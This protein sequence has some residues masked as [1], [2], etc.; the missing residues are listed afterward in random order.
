MP[1]PLQGLD[2]QARA[3]SLA[4]EIESHRTQ[5]PVKISDDTTNEFPAMLVPKDPY[6]SVWQ[7]KQQNIA[8]NPFGAQ[9]KVQFVQEITPE[10]LAY[11]RRKAD[12]LENIQFEKWLHSVIDMSNPA[13]VA[14]ARENG[15]LD[16][17]FEQRKKVIDNA[18]E[19]SRKIAHMRLLGQ[20]SWRYPDYKLAYALKTGVL[21][22]PTGSLMNPASY[23]T[24]GS[25][26]AGY[27]RGYFNPRRF[28]PAITG[29][30]L[31]NREDPFPELDIANGSIIGDISSKQFDGKFNAISSPN[32]PLQ[33]GLAPY[34]P[35]PAQ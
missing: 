26:D 29:G 14:M 12:V 21:K 33:L 11:Q 18:H 27:R 34:K 7:Q 31:K 3:S 8:Q 23:L 4:S 13:Q 1:S 5:P 2:A 17:Y 19:V 24:G 25:G 32:A 15:V 35:A 6:D 20:S 10:D 9:D 22:L 16:G 28:L 30:K